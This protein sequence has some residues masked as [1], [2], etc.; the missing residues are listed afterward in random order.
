MKRNW[1]AGL[2]L[3]FLLAGCAA[4]KSGCPGSTFYNANNAKQNG[5]AGKQM[6]LF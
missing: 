3:A 6:R 2:A 4:Q 1:W 5:K